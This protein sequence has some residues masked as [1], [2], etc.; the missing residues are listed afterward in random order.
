MNKIISHQENNGKIKE[1]NNTKER[2]I[3]R[4]RKHIRVYW[5]NI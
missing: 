1:D 3:A 2:K 4:R 5:I